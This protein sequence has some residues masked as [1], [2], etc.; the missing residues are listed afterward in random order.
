MGRVEKII[1]SIV[2]EPFN[3]LREFDKC[4]QYLH[5][6]D[7]YRNLPLMQV[8]TD[9]LIPTQ[10]TVDQSKIDGIIEDEAYDGILVFV[11]GT[12]SW[13]LDGHHRSAAATQAGR[14]TIWA[15]VWKPD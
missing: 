7:D 8:R 10:A 12:K 11:R 2:P 3:G 6:N 4:N 1:E 5:G 14:S 13:V 15:H 9:M